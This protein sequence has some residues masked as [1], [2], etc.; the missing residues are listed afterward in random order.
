VPLRIGFDMDGVFADMTSALRREAD[1]LVAARASASMDESAS[2]P[3]GEGA[4]AEG[5]QDQRP[6]LALTAREHR[7]LWRRVGAIDRFWECLDEIEPGSVARL[8]RLATERGWEVIFLTKRPATA[9]P[10][11]QVQTQR[12]LMARGFP[13]PSVFVVQGSRGLIAAALHLD[14]VVDDTPSNCLDVV[15][16]SRAG[17]VL[18]WRGKDDATEPVAARR[19]NIAV[20]K[21]VGECLDVLV[22]IDTPRQ[23]QGVVDR[24]LVRMGLRSRPKPAWRK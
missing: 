22:E 8:G 19:M 17:S 24:F 13:M 23:A 3:E 11:A 4:A 9:G 15:S 5:E 2:T 1:V 6:E 20:V 10:P 16:E 12:W 18:V 7:A 14:F 21:S